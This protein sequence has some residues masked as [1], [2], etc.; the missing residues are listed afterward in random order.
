MNYFIHLTN[1]AVQVK[2][3]SYGAVVK[4]NILSLKDFEVVT[5][6]PRKLFSAN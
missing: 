3:D 1:N 4:G 6:D 2:S 5:D